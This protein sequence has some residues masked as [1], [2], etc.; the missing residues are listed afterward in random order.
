MSISFNQVPQNI[1]TPF[2][3]IEF[4][5]EEAN[6]GLT[7]QPYTALLI[8]SKLDSG[9]A[10]K[11]KPIRVTSNEQAITYFGKGSQLVAMVE[12]FRKVDSFTSLYCL[13]FEDGSGA[14]ATGKLTVDGTATAPG[15]L[16]LYLGGQRLMIGVDMDDTPEI[17]AA[18][19]VTA[20][21]SANVPVSASATAGEVTLT[22]KNKGSL[23]NDIDLRLNFYDGE[24][25]PAGLTVTVVQMSG[26]TGNPDIEDAIKL[27]DEETHYNIIGMGYADT[28]NLMLL[29]EELDVRWGP[30]DQREG[31]AFFSGRGTHTELSNEGKKWN[32][33]CFCFVHAAK[34]PSSPWEVAAS[35]AALAAYYGNIDPAR[36]FQTLPM[37][38]IMAPKIEERFRQQERNLLL[39]DGVSTWTVDAGSTVRAERF[40]T[41]YRKTPSGA[42]DP[43]YLDVTTILT[44]SRLRWSLRTWLMQ[45]YPRHKLASGDISVYGRGQAIAT[46]ESVKADIV[47]WFLEHL[48]Q[49]LV[50]DSKS[51]IENTFVE[52]N[53]MDVNRLD[54][55]LAPDLVNQLIVLAAKMAFRL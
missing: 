43:S 25:S 31:V 27:L 11:E 1:R 33:Q 34:T 40:I 49:G 36:P 38:G 51:F 53:A 54:I 45:R 35:A 5:N 46:P 22:A 2:V 44:L 23:G 15:T 39:Y 10:E 13:P 16:Y 20:V 48:N 47:S 12:S 41:T 29:R 24:E 9:T 26:G 7:S 18:A 32:Y 37:T 55:Y 19:I 6:K 30:M 4:S 14:A 17:V 8:G 3:A 52:R 28:A 50:E 42:D 21:E